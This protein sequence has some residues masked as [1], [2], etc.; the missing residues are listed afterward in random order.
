MGLR[1]VRV[2]QDI[3]TCAA[4][5]LTQARTLVSQILLVIFAVTMPYRAGLVA[6]CID[7]DCAPSIEL[8]AKTDD[9]GG[10][11]D[12]ERTAKAE[13]LTKSS[14]D[15]CLKFA[16][17]GPTITTDSSKFAKNEAV[18]RLIETFQM[19]AAR[20]MPELRMVSSAY[21]VRNNSSLSQNANI[22]L[23]L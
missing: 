8:A 19:V 15:C 20:T 18:L 3:L 22:V 10:C 17:S 7:S 5:L 11:L 2:L 6:L 23:Q 14:I 21:I 12:E 9:C 13:T 16:S 1:V 4:M